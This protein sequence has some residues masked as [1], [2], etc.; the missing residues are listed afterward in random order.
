MADRLEHRVLSGGYGSFR[1]EEIKEIAERIGRDITGAP[2][3]NTGITSELDI[4][5]PEVAGITGA[6]EVANPDLQRKLCPSKPREDII[7]IA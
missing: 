3:S 4:Y 7:D 2:V 5:G 1:K 6:L